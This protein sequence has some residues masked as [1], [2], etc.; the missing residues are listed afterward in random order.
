MK[1]RA[2]CQA[3]K[4]EF[5]TGDRSLDVH[6]GG[7]KVTAGV[8]LVKEGQSIAVLGTALLGSASLGL[9]KEATD[10]PCEP[11]TCEFGAV[12]QQSRWNNGC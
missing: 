2:Y 1:G 8:L 6:Q 7:S 12:C 5:N 4:R 11:S 10:H 3:V 9:R